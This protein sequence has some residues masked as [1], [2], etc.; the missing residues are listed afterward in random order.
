MTKTPS[1]PLAG[2]DGAR[3][4]GWARA[5]AAETKLA[6]LTADL[7]AP[8]WTVNAS[9]WE[10]VTVRPED[11]AFVRFSVDGVQMPEIWVRLSCNRALELARSL[12]AAV[13]YAEAHPPRPE[14]TRRATEPTPEGEQ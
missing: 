7:P 12:I 2:L 14:P 3:R 4:A 8:R 10:A 11:D 1:D 9:P 13:Q 5:Y 6:E